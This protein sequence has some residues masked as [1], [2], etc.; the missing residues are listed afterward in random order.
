MANIDDSAKRYVYS[1]ALI[2]K[3]ISQNVL[4]TSHEL[5]SQRTIYVI[6]LQLNFLIKH[7]HVRLMLLVF[8]LQFCT[9]CKFVSVIAMTSTHIAVSGSTLESVARRDISEFLSAWGECVFR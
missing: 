4:R 5:N 3:V 6:N 7:P 1:G 8:C 2:F 9:T